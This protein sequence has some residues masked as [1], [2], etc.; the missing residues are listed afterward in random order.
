MNRNK[1]KRPAVFRTV[2]ILVIIFVVAS[3]AAIR[4]ANRPSAAGVDPKIIAQLADCLSQKGAKM[5]GTYWCP[6]CQAQKK[7]FGA[8]FSKINYVECS[9]QG[10]PREQTQACKDAGIMSY[11]TWVFPNG[12]RTSGEIAFKDLADKAGCPFGPTVLAPAADTN[13]L[14]SEQPTVEI[15]PA[16]A[17]TNAAAK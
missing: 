10:N 2:I 16:Q 12:D 15:H 7:L 13:L 8:A 6:H 9:P 1:D 4:Y 14:P 11:P 5:Y 3:I 17:P